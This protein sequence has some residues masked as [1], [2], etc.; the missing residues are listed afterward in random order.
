MTGA[1]NKAGHCTSKEDKHQR[2]NPVNTSQKTNISW[3]TV[4][5]LVLLFAP[6]LFA[7]K[8]GS[9]QNFESG[10]GTEDEY[11]T[12]AWNCTVDFDGKK[13]HSGS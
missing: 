9:L 11:D 1:L 6:A 13:M 3:I 7:Q 5:V 10:N 2:G 12:Q 8:K 4:G